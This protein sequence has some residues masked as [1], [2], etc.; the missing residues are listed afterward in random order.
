MNVLDENIPEDQRQL[1][2][3]WKIHTCQIGQDVGQPGM[4]DQEQII[5]LLTQLPRPTFFTRDLGFFDPR[6]CHERYGLVCL[7]VDAD[8]TATYIRRVLRHSAVNT[9]CKRLA[10]AIRVSRTGIQ[11]LKR[12]G[13]EERL[14]W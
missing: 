9:K 3:R 5:P 11:V 1:L 13:L 8:E 14:D 12:H 4:K 7:A 10:R 2:R 6:L